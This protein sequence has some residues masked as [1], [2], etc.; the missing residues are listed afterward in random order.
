MGDRI[1]GE[2]GDGARN[3]VIGKDITQHVGN[4]TVAWR[5]FV[6]RDLESLGG[7][8]VILLIAVMILFVLGAVATGL[9]VRQIDMI[10]G[11]IDRIE[12]R[13]D[14]HRQYYHPYNPPYNP[15]P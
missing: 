13:I 11:H 12:E 9:V 1:E 2:V 8:V 14:Q 6:R 4:G 10:Y 15:L 5:E 7:K 3:V